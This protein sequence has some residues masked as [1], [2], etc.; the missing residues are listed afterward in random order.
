MASRKPSAAELERQFTAWQRQQPKE[1]R[2]AR[3]LE[4]CDRDMKGRQTRELRKLKRL[5]ARD[6]EL[7]HKQFQM[8][9]VLP[10][11]DPKHLAWAKRLVWTTRGRGDFRRIE[12]ELLYVK[13]QVE[14]RSIGVLGDERHD[15]F[16][17]PDPLHVHW[18][19]LRHIVSSATHDGFVGRS[20]RFLVRDRHSLQYLGLLCISGDMLELTPRNDYI[21]WTREQHTDEH[22]INFLAN[23]QT[24][25]PTQPFGTLYNGGKLLALLALSDVVAKAWQS[26]YGDRLVGLTTTSLW[27][28]DHAISMYDMLKPYWL[29]TKKLSPKTNGRTSGATQLLPAQELFAA[30]KQWMKARHPRAFWDYFVAKGRDNMMLKRDNKNRALGVCYTK[31]G[32]PNALTHSGYQRG[33]YFAPLYTNTNE[34]LRNE[35]DKSE[36]QPKFLNQLGDLVGAW[37]ADEIEGKVGVAKKRLDRL[38]ADRRWTPTPPSYYDVLATMTWQQARERFG[39][40]SLKTGLNAQVVD[41]TTL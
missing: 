25:V 28:N 20:L 5:S 10:K 4:Q 21:G 19:I 31:L 3:A 11:L 36:L 27:G 34:F 32:L 2:S 26:T 1:T 18:N 9:E 6:Y 37:R 8:R 24:C 33:V 39:S 15:T 35:I 30:L 13:P 16:D 40:K 22:R 7:Y 38:D 41:T 23:V 14:I 17:A 12:P 29:N